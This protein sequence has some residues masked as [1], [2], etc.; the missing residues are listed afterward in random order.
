MYMQSSC[1]KPPTACSYAVDAT[2]LAQDLDCYRWNNHP[3]L[4]CYE[5]DS[6][7]AGVLETMRI[8]WRKLSILNIVMV[9]LLICIY[10][11]GCCA[12]QNTKRAQ[13]DNPYGQNRMSKV[14]PRWDFYWY[15]KQHSIVCTARINAIN[16]ELL[17]HTHTHKKAR[18]DQVYSTTT[19]E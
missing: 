16:T 18:C 1:C 19:C 2:T 11:V 8:D 3:N 9:I 7:K 4:L 5:C 10:S 13:T 14:R 12:Y 17:T 15:V 6:C